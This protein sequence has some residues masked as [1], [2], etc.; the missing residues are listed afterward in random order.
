MTY[1]A[2]R[3]A[4]SDAASESAARSEILRWLMEDSWKERYIDNL[5][6]QLC[7][8][9]PQVGIPVD[10][11]TIHFRVQHPQWLGARIL[12]KKGADTVINRFDHGIDNAP[13]YLASPTKAIIEGDDEIRAKL[14]PGAD[15]AYEVYDFFLSEGFTEYVAWPLRHTFG[16]RH[17]LSFATKKEGGFD[18]GAFAFLKSLVAPLSLLSEVRT[19]N[20]LARTLLQTYVGPRAA[21]E[22]LSGSITR[23]SGD[24]LRAAI[25]ICDMRD[26]TTLSNLW[27]RDDVIEL[28][29]SYFDALCVPVE[30][31]GGEILKFMGDG[32][33]SVFPLNQPQA[34]ERLLAAVEEANRRMAVLNQTNREAGKPELRYGV[35]IHIGDVMYGNIGS[36][37]RLDFTVIGPAV[38]IASRLEALTK[39][40]GRSVL[41]SVEFAAALGEQT[42]DRFEAIGERALRGVDQSVRVFAL[43]GF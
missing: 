28:L 35:G 29:N 24:T 43:T 9:L 4:A 10:R 23:G 31:N 21:E 32:M 6:T 16:K 5:L 38:N 30:E 13:Q 33:L 11:A 36:E 22:I 15:Q 42:S 27:P 2:Q 7:E 39:T 18:E 8:R 3:N 34:A 19:K 26:F 20:V 37:A 12:W 17:M 41:A 1:A 25:M 14:V 40:E